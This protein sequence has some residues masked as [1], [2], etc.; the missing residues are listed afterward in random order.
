MQREVK[1]LTQALVNEAITPNGDR[2]QVVEDLAGA[3]EKPM[4]LKPDNET[5]EARKKLRMPSTLAA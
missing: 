3:D 2:F 1:S 4:I 5:G